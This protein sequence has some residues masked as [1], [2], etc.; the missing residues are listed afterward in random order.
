LAPEQCTKSR[1]TS[2]LPTGFLNFAQPYR[3]YG[4]RIQ[5][6]WDWDSGLWMV[7]GVRIAPGVGH[8]CRLT[9]ER[10]LRLQPFTHTHAWAYPMGLQK[11]ANCNSDLIAC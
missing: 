9:P 4:A 6:G 8:T 7:T 2:Q 1:S 11:G 10:N 3:H 5:L